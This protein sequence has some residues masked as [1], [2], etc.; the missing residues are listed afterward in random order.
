MG[1]DSGVRIKRMESFLC[2]M[3]LSGKTENESVVICF[4][5]HW[6]IRDQHNVSHNGSFNTDSHSLDVLDLTVCFNVCVHLF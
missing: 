3:F 1:V 5:S 2:S 6:Q 4:V